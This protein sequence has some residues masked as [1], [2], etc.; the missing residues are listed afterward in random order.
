[1]DLI[2]IVVWY[3]LKCNVTF[4][5]VLIGI[6]KQIFVL[7]AKHNNRIVHGFLIGGEWSVGERKF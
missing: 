5:D 1:M 3:G 6:A 7:H 2:G 4:G